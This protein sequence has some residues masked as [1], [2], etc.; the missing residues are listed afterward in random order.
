VLR[1]RAL[2]LTIGS[3]SRQNGRRDANARM[4]VWIDAE[5]ELLPD[6]GF[7]GLRPACS[8]SAR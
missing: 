6:A 8:Q 1:A 2:P 3:R 7:E 5:H 4:Y